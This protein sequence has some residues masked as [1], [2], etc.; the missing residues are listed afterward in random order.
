MGTGLIGYAKGSFLTPIHMEIFGW[1]TTTALVFDLGV[2]LSV[3]GVILAALNL[4]GRQHRVSQQLA[5]HDPD[6]P[7]FVHDDTSTHDTE[8]VTT[9]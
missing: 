8:E 1:H 2:Y 4:L 6:D 7:G 5:W 3:I 9:R